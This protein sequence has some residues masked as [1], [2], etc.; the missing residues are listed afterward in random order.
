MPAG[1]VVYKEHTT[2]PLLNY[3]RGRVY[4]IMTFQRP[5]Q[6]KLTNTHFQA[7]WFLLQTYDW[8]IQRN[9]YF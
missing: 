3:T 7:A 8:N 1:M 6:R 9:G 4:I 5:K 2:T